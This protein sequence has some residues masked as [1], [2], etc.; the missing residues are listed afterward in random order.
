M[1]GNSEIVGTASQIYVALAF[2]LL[3]ILLWLFWFRPFWALLILFATRPL[4]ALT[5]DVDFSLGPFHL[6]LLAFYSLAMIAMAVSWLLMRKRFKMPL[7]PGFL[8]ITFLAYGAASLSYSLDPAQGIGDLLRIATGFMFFWFVYNVIDDRDQVLAVLKWIALSSF[9]PIAYGLWQFFTK[10]GYFD[11][12]PQLMRLNS[13]F[14]LPTV[15]ANYLML[16]SLLLI[17]LVLL[18]GIAR[19]TVYVVILAAAMASLVLTW[20]RTSWVGFVAGLLVLML[21]KER[22]WLTLPLSTV[23]IVVLII[24]IPQTRGRFMASFEKREAGKSSWDTRVNLWQSSLKATMEKPIL[25]HGI[26]SA[27][28][29]VKKAGKLKVGKIP[30][31]DYLRLLIEVGSL[32]F[33]IFSGL[34]LALLARLLSLI[35]VEK[36]RMALEL[37]RLNIAIV[38]SCGAAAIA[39]NVITD[40]TILMYVF[41]LV[42]CSFK[43]GEIGEAYS[44][45]S[46]YDGVSVPGRPLYERPK[47]GFG[48]NRRRR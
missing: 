34:I 29:V 43:L 6:N 25:G 4:V 20:G 38:F 47:P 18:R 40:V 8:M 3:F 26:G 41:S 10:T 48:I 19:K 17:S 33:L 30:H 24:S 15:Y 32:G 11:P 35:R 23:L 36:D 16:I 13:T 45:N 14:I 5:R 37:H 39:E 9:I 22:Q 2:F 42:A 12:G 31:N 1:V 21:L 7:L 46:A 27:L 44:Q 28:I